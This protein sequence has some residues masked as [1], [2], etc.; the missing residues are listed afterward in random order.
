MWTPNAHSPIARMHIAATKKLNSPET[1]HIVGE[2]DALLNEHNEL[3]KLFKSH[4]HKLQSENHAFVINPVRLLGQLV[5]HIF[6]H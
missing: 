5:I 1:R 3:L 4:M 6:L 2:L